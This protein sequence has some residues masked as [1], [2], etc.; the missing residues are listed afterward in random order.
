MAVWARVETKCNKPARYR[1]GTLQVRRWLSDIPIGWCL[2]LWLCTIKSTTSTK[3]CTCKCQVW[4][5]PSHCTEHPP[6][7]GILVTSL[8]NE[9]LNQP[10]ESLGSRAHGC[11]AHFSSKSRFR[12]GRRCFWR[13]STLYRF[14]LSLRTNSGMEYRPFHWEDDLERWT[15]IAI[16]VLAGT[17]L[18][19][20]FIPKNTWQTMH[21][22]ADHD[23]KSARTTVRVVFQTLHIAQPRFQTGEQ[24]WTKWI[25][26]NEGTWEIRGQH[27][28]HNAKNGLNNEEMHFLKKWKLGEQSDKALHQASCNM[29][30]KTIVFRSFCEVG[31]PKNWMSEAKSK[32]GDK[33]QHQI[34]QSFQVTSLGSNKAL[35]FV[36]ASFTHGIKQKKPIACHPLQC[37][38]HW[39]HEKGYDWRVWKEEVGIVKRI[40]WHNQQFCVEC[41]KTWCSSNFGFWQ[42][43]KHHQTQYW[44]YID[45]LPWIFFS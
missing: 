7:H 29:H 30:C 32:H 25:R 20:Q 14:D 11:C 3:L 4:D 42:A 33:D 27:S 44:T 43:L 36:N 40:R 45:S 35:L 5:W 2:Q 15:F 18:T 24:K 28:K 19:T 34:F 31:L 21:A 9:S 22:F 39:R 13:A 6:H 17:T 12:P 38:H 16:I 41:C 1:P 26:L 37:H 8:S 23:A 10:F